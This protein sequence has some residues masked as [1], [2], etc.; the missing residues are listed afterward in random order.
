MP[1]IKTYKVFEY[2]LEG[3]N[4]KE[5]L[6]YLN[7]CI[8]EAHFQLSLYGP[9]KFRERKRV[10]LDDISKRAAEKLNKLNLDGGGN[11]RRT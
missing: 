11:D 6:L 3:A 5:Q 1:H 10:I 9:G 7:E 4:T 2:Y 8:T